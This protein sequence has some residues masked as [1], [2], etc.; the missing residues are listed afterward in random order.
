[1]RGANETGLPDTFAEQ[2][3]APEDLYHTT[4]TRKAL[5]PAGR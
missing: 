5:G 2:P 3:L 1:M 4:W